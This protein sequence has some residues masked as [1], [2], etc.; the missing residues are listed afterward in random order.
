M[1]LG[2]IRDAVYSVGKIVKRAK[3]S[4]FQEQKLCARLSVGPSRNQQKRNWN[5]NDT[6]GAGHSRIKLAIL[7]W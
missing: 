4:Y 2:N 1:F 5:R 3:Y 6:G 7:R